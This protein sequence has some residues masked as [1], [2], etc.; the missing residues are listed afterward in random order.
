M[1]AGYGGCG[2]EENMIIGLERLTVRKD[3]KEIHI[4]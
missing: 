4:P 2:K 3:K 1:T